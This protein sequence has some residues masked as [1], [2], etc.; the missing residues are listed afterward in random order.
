MKMWI[1]HNGRPPLCFLRRSPLFY[2]HYEHLWCQTPWPTLERFF[3]RGSL[4]KWLYLAKGQI[5]CLSLWLSVSTDTV[6]ER[7]G[8]VLTL[9]QDVRWIVLAFYPSLLFLVLSLSFSISPFGL[10]FPAF[11][12]AFRGNDCLICI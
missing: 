4:C 10:C 3:L 11:K 2:S 8:Q 5:V 9:H 6:K 12:Q 1:P 7:G